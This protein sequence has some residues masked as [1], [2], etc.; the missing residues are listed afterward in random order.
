M[1]IAALLLLSVLIGCSSKMMDNKTAEEKMTRS[2]R[3]DRYSLFMQIGRVGS[4]CGSDSVQ[5]IELTKNLTPTSSEVTLAAKA[6]GYITIVPDGPNFWKVELTEKGKSAIDRKPYGKTT[7]NG[8]DYQQVNLPLATRELVKITGITA[9]E[10]NPEV[11]YLWRWKPTEFGEALR[12]GG[13]AFVVLTPDQRSELVQ[14]M[15][16]G[17]PDLPIPVPPGDFVA[18]GV[19]RF[20]KFTDGWRPQR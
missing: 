13:A 6:L 1:R 3:T 2:L 20:K 18:K 19:T 14:G 7:E 16:G 9:D 12:E 10:N 4:N 11:E 8:C 5:G 15:M 17:H